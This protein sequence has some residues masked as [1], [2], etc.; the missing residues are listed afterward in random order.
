MADKN[1]RSS[2]PGFSNIEEPLKI[3]LNL[4]K[5]LAYPTADT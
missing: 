4:V 5:L 1:L 3:L 2:K